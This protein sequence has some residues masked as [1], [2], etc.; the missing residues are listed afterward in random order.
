MQR[1]HQRPPGRP[2]VS[3][4]DTPTSDTILQ[5]AANLFMEV[6]YEAGTIAAVAK[7]CGVT[8]ATIYYYFPTKAD[9]FTAAVLQLMDTIRR[10]TERILEQEAPLLDRLRGIGTVRLKVQ[11]HH[12]DFDLIMREA[13]PT[14]SAQ[15]LAA[16]RKAEDQLISTLARA[17]SEASASGEIRPV[18]SVLAAHAFVALLSVGGVR[19][20]NGGM[21]FPDADRIAGD[22]IDLYWHGLTMLD[23]ESEQIFLKRPIH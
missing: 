1:S 23:D 17:F 6:G 9:L 22:L 14:L 15:Q 7:Q 13:E 11:Q 20:R 3:S 2:R 5:V 18:N 4:E 10:R 8:K 21:Q 19:N 16:M 12:L